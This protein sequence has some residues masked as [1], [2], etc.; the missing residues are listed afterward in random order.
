MTCYKFGNHAGHFLR[1]YLNASIFK[2]DDATLNLI[3]ALIIRFQ[4]GF[5]ILSPSGLSRLKCNLCNF[6]KER[7][8]LPSASH[9]HCLQQ[10]LRLSIIPL[11][12]PRF[13]L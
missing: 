3:E 7:L 11:K 5:T 13:S 10:Y 4:S 6:I 1:I 2:N 8:I 12:K 9:W